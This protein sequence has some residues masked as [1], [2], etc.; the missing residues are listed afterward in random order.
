MNTQNL[1]ILAQA[2]FCPNLTNQNSRRIWFYLHSLRVPLT[3]NSCVQS[4]R[5]CNLP[6]AI[7]EDR[8]ASISFDQAAAVTLKIRM[9]ESNTGSELFL[10]LR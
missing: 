5:S 4:F 1:I 7:S 8:T 3:P 9:N 6:T 10:L 2:K